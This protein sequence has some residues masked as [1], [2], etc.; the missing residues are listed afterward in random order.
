MS[1]M[2]HITCTDEDD[3]ETHR[4]DME[5]ASVFSRGETRPVTLL[6]N[7]RTVERTPDLCEWCHPG[8]SVAGFP[9]SRSAGTRSAGASP[10]KRKGSTPATPA[11]YNY[12]PFRV[13]TSSGV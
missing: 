6:R 9:G 4:S 12:S 8:I 2:E 10:Y 3:E 11:K 7:T 13:R 5:V 1:D